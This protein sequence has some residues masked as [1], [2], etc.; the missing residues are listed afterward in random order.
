LSS[1][2]KAFLSLNRGTAHSIPMSTGRANQGLVE[3]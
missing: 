1:Q 3:A 2:L